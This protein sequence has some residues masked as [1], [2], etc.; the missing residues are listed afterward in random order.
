M[1]KKRKKINQDFET[2]NKSGGLEAPPEKV[3]EIKF[4][5]PAIFG[6]SVLFGLILNYFF[7]HFRTNL[8]F[9]LPLGCLVTIFGIFI[10]MWTMNK[11]RLFKT[12]PHPKHQPFKLI[13]SGPYKYSRNPLYLGTFLMIFGFGAASDILLISISSI[14]SLIFIH[15]FVVLPEEEYLIELFGDL[16]IQYKKQVRRWL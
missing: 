8:S 13:T 11:Y 1:F 7:D 10:N 5:P 4:Q 3:L 9:L 16:F 12:S 15:F 2:Y 6:I 14:F